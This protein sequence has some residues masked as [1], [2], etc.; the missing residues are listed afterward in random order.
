ALAVFDATNNL[1]QLTGNSVS[2]SLTTGDI[3]DDWSASF[4]DRVAPRFLKTPTTSTIQ[5]F[6]RDVQGGTLTTRSSGVFADHKYD[7]TQDARWHRFSMSFTGDVEIVGADYR[8]R[9]SGQR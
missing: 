2:S 6:S 9:K 8:M 5:G 3:G 1:V 7:I 4:L